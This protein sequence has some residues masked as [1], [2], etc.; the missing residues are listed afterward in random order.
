VNRFEIEVAKGNND[1]QNGRFVKLGEV[2]SPGNSNSERAYSFTDNEPGKSGVRYYRLKII[3]H[4]NS[5]VYSP[6]RPVVF[7]D[8]IKWQV[9]PNPSKGAY[10]LTYQLNQGEVLDLKIYDVTGKL[11]KQANLTGN[12]FVQNADI[13]LQPVKY[14]PGVYLLIA[15]S[16]EKKYNIRLIKQ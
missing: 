11:V 5:F 4:D 7:N 1:Y 2:L 10:N 15:Q 6:V 16:G 3:D 12:G 14:A 9:F 13:D 8:E